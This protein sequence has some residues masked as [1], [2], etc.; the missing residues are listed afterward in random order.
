MKQIIL[1]CETSS[2]NTHRKGLTV[3]EVTCLSIFLSGF[4][5][6]SCTH[7]HSAQ[8]RLILDAGFCAHQ[9]CPVI[10]PDTG[11]NEFV[12]TINN[13]KFLIAFSILRA[14]LLHKMAQQ[15]PRPSSAISD[16]ENR[17]EVARECGCVGSVSIAVWT[18]LCTFRLGSTPRTSRQWHHVTSW[19]RG[20]RRTERSRRRELE[21]ASLEGNQCASR[22]R[23]TS[24]GERP[25]RGSKEP[26]PPNPSGTPDEGHQPLVFW[27]HVLLTFRFRCRSAVCS[28]LSVHGV[29]RATP[30]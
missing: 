11:N 29:Q 2:F 30:T 22:K 18:G 14:D 16:F 21:S 23:R 20:R 24:L 8:Y 9:S 15:M 17:T 28:T 4:E 27:L 3:V 7:V 26:P 10:G 25:E 6:Y 5:H 12:S 1:V 19:Q 13:C